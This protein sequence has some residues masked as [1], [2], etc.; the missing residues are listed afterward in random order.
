MTLRIAQLGQPVLRGLARPLAPEEVSTPQ[1]RAFLQLM[2]ETLEEAGGVGLA[3]PQVF[4]ELRVFLAR[5]GPPPAEGEL[6]PAE[7]FI[8][9]QLAPIGDEQVSRWEG[10]LSFPELL[11][12][13]PRAKRVRIEYVDETGQA[14]QQE[15]EDFPARVVQHEN[16][17]LDGV[18]TLDRAV[19][20][21][22]IIK[23]SEAESVQGPP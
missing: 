20:T 4:A 14:R 15:L 16:D 18:L 9:P 1:F 12:L 3:G 13:V 21:R 11:V 23:A 22:H 5:V 2:R 10:C 19:S 8:N 7:V 17:H 6:A